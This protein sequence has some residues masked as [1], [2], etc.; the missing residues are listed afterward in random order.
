MKSRVNFVLRANS[1]EKNINKQ[2]EWLLVKGIL[3]RFSSVLGIGKCQN[4]NC[5]YELQL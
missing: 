3:A 5:M 4:Q 1:W 2:I